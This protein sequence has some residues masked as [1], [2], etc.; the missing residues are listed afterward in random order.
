MISGMKEVK[1]INEENKGN[2]IVEITKE[3]INNKK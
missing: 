2:F 1:L 3:I